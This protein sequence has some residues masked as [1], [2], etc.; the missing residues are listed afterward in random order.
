[1][2]TKRAPFAGSFFALPLYF[3]ALSF[4]R[5]APVAQTGFDRDDPLWEIYVPAESGST[6]C[7][8][9]IGKVGKVSPHRGTSCAILSAQ[10]PAR[11]GVKPQGN[12]I[13]VVPGEKYLF[14]AWVKA[15]PGW[16]AAPDSPGVVLQGRVRDTFQKDLRSGSLLIGFKGVAHNPAKLSGPVL[17]TTWVKLEGVIEM[18]LGAAD[19]IPFVFVW[20]GSG[21]A[22]IDDISIEKVSAETQLTP[23]LD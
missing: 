13:V 4:L 5:A 6:G 8:F 1:M 15:G 19:M 7:A 18:P 14:R 12:P 16:L 22:L 9:T 20:K 2:T 21:E 10:I 17:S 23:V 11:V 3:A